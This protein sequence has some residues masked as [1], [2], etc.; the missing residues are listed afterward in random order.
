MVKKMNII[1]FGSTADSVIVLDSLFT[2]QTKQL[3]IQAVVTQPPKPI[4][5]KQILTPTPVETW[6]K[7]HAVTCLTFETQKEKPWIYKD[8]HRVVEAL[9]TF[10]PDL[11]ISASYGQKI[12]EAT[13]TKI[14]LGGVNVHPSILPRWR[15]TDPI[16]W[17]I[18]AGDAQTGVTLVTLSTKFDQGL[19]LAEQ[20]IPMPIA[21]TPEEIRTRLFTLGAHLLTDILPPY[22]SGKHMGNPQDETHA[23]YARRI[24]KDDG[25]IP[26]NTIK[27]ALSGNTMQKENLPAIFAITEA[28]LSES[29]IRAVRAFSP[30]PGVW[31]MISLDNEGLKR[32]KILKTHAEN[33]KLIIDT[34]QLEGKK[35]T[36]F[37]IFSKAYKLTLDNI[38]T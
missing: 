24:T 25:Y 13:L 22:C 15:G 32:L 33:G 27:N 20:K 1:F 4:G 7:L 34:V 23:T 35:P 36:E 6:A 3:E 16:P 38:I 11:L 29:I 10:T 14:P 18:L 9:S 2:H 21:D 19:I 12:P 28:P 31:T 17:T 5:R 30:W 8:D 26:W 37:A